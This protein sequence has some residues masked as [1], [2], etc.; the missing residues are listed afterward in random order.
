MYLIVVVANNLFPYERVQYLIER[1]YVLA[2]RGQK[3][4]FPEQMVTVYDP[5]IDSASRS[6]ASSI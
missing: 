6:S 5:M 1:C 2:V 4:R 3:A